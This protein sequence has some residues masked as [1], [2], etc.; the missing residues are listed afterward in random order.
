MTDKRQPSFSDI[1]TSTFRDKHYEPDK[2]TRDR[3]VREMHLGPHHIR[4]RFEFA[5]AIG[6]ADIL[7][8]NI[9]ARNPLFD[10]LRKKAA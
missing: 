3:S 9:A 7:A 5:G 2:S 1:V 6:M 4:H 8:E 10:M